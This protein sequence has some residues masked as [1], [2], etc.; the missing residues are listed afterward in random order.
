MALSNF[1]KSKYNRQK[2]LFFIS[3][4]IMFLLLIKFFHITVIKHKELNVSSE[5]NCLRKVHYDQAQ[6]ALIRE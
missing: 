4:L 2:A 5:A 6:G 1:N 3:I